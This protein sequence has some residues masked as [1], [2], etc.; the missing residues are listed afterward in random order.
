MHIRVIGGGPGGLLFASIAKRRHPDWNV[1]VLER[2]QAGRTYGHG[3]VL[4]SR[5]QSMLAARVPKIFNR[6]RS[7]AVP[8]RHLEVRHRAKRFRCGNYHFLGIRRATLLQTLWD[9]AVESGVDVRPEVE[10]S[11]PLAERERADLLVAADGAGSVAR[12][13]WEREFG[14]AVCDAEEAFLWLSVPKRFECLCFPFER[15]EGV[16]WV[17]AHA[18]PHSERESTFIIEAPR[19]IAERIQEIDANGGAGSESP[20]VHLFDDHLDEPLDLDDAAW[21]TFRVVRCERWYHENVALVGDSAHTAHFSIGSGTGLAFGDAIAL[22]DALDSRSPLEE[23]LRAYDAE[24]RPVVEEFARL[25][26]V[27]QEWWEGLDDFG[28]M[29]AEE[30]VAH[31]MTRVPVVSRSTLWLFDPT[32]VTALEKTRRTGQGALPRHWPGRIG[33]L[34][35]PGRLVA[36]TEAAQAM[37][38]DEAVDRGIGLI[39]CSADDPDA[40]LAIGEW[41][42]RLA[43]REPERRPTLGAAIRPGANGSA[44]EAELRARLEGLC[45]AG[46][47]L[48]LVRIDGASMPDGTELG[49]DWTSLTS[50]LPGVPVVPLLEA[51]EA[52]LALAERAATA[53]AL[54]VGFW[55][56]DAHDR[57]LVHCC[58]RARL[59]TGVPVLMMDAP[60]SER[61][62]ADTHILSGRVDFALAALS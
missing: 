62:L 5:N 58:E 45:S 24:R 2:S 37:G 30:L 28:E 56:V 43:G 14:A 4:P 15:V 25:S 50:L 17:G 1:T 22:C 13:M 51:T 60:E 21:H 59:R 61:S 20:L 55:A 16:G 44:A 8:W 38:A 47:E 39:L 53:G 36:D 34:R 49:G 10:V 27:S 6:L 3:V 26:R 11:D 42:S 12:R 57:A 32:F 33:P 18:Y 29:P 19:A 46:V 9:I 40:V 31:F 54:A 41:K 7:V 23:R 52:G 48:L 35:L